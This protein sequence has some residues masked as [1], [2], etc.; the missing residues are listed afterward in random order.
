MGRKMFGRLDLRLVFC[1]RVEGEL[2]ERERETG[3]YIY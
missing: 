3:I 2:T 1:A